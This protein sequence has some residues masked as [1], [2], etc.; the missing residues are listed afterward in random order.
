M[1]RVYELKEFSYNEK[2]RKVLILKEEADG[3]S[4][5]DLNAL[6]EAE[7]EELEQAKAKFDEAISKY[8][9]L[10]YKRFKTELVIDKAVVDGEQ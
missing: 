7:R 9:K 2:E 10:G 4:G 1:S 5:I 3:F 8:L 6:G